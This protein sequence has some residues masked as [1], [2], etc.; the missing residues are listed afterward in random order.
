MQTDRESENYGSKLKKTVLT[1]LAHTVLLSSLLLPTM[2][3]RFVGRLHLISSRDD[4]SSVL[5][6]CTRPRRVNIRSEISII[7]DSFP[8]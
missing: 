5:D 1:S 3:L 6:M 8:R 7:P 4:Y 2:V